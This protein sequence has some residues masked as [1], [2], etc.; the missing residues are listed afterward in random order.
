MPYISRLLT[1]GALLPLLLTACGGTPDVTN[2]NQP[3]NPDITGS[4]GPDSGLDS[5][6]GVDSGVDLNLGLGGGGNGEA[7]ASAIGNGGAD[8]SGPTC[9][10]G[11]IEA[12][13]TC[14]DGNAKPGDGCDGNCQTEKN[15][16][17]AT[18]GKPCVSKPTSSV[19]G[20]GVIEDGETCDLGS[21]KNDGTQGC[22]ATCQAVPGWTCPATGEACTRDAYCGDGNVQTTLGEQCDDGTNNGQQGCSAT[23]Q[24]ITGWKCP[25][26]G[27]A[28]SVDAYCGNGAIDPGE[29]CDDHNRR[30]Y[31]GCSSTCFVES[32]WSCPPAGGACS[33]VCGNGVIDSGE[34]CD[35]GN[36]YSGDGCSSTCQLEASYTCSVVGKPCLFTPPPQ[37]PQCGNGVIQTGEGCDDGNA[38]SGDGCSS[39]CQLEGGWKC[40]AANTACIAA[41]CGDGILAGTEQCDDGIVDNKHGCSSTCTIMPNAVCP[42]N[43]GLCVPMV[44]G[45]GKVTG[46]EQCDDGSND[47]KHGCSTTCQ[48]IA[49]WQCPLAG[50]QCIPV[51]GDGLVVG[52]EQCDEKADVPCCTATCKLKAGFVCDPSKTHIRNPLLPIAA[53]RSW[54]AP[55]TPAA[56]YAGPSNA[57]TGTRC[58]STVAHPPVLTSRYAARR[59]PTS[60]ARPPWLFNA[61]RI[62]A[63]GSCCLRNNVTTATRR[64]ATAA[65]TTATSRQFRARAPR[66]GPA[67]NR[68]PAPHSPYPSSGAIFRPESH[69]QFS[70]DPLVNRRLPGIPQNA[71]Q[72]VAIPGPRQFKYVPAYN[73]AYASPAFGNGITASQTGP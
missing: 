44:C 28:C 19:C 61:S 5:G 50:T 12:P 56:Q 65:I 40:P 30:S 4:D 52:D 59:I 26:T 22:S 49:G 34:T 9:G 15:W 31:D 63:T 48:V 27:G 43:G 64:T 8:D 39:T 17:C 41:K 33:R 2:H 51:C 6:T 68:R 21:A 42:A 37:P 73:T 25:P 70:I 53:T 36:F 10:D 18:P 67:F 7:G 71:L 38:Q 60:R 55:R 3:I 58:P 11:V 66:L 16:V 35:D 23:C 46:T 14:D 13:E 72:P 54:T 1:L 32:G 57:T 69:P 62:A 45:D 47:G 24:V 29:Q 20:N